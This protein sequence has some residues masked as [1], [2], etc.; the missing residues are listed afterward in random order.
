MGTLS[1][2][3]PHYVRCIKPNDTKEAFQFHPA[4]AVN[5]LRA[6]GVL[7][8]IRISAAGFPSRWL[9]QDF[10]HRYRL[11]CLHKEID[12]GDI[13]GTCGR[14]LAKHLKDPD[15]YQ[16]G[17]TKIFFRAGQV[18]YLEKIRA[19]IQRLYCVR[20]QSC[21]RRFVARQ[22]YLRLTR[23]LRGLQARARGFLARRFVVRQKYLRLTRALRGLQARARGFLARRAKLELLKLVE[24][25][26]K[27]L[28]AGNNDKDSLIAALQAELTSERD[29][30]K[31]LI[32]E[33]KE[34]EQAYKKEREEWQA[35]S[36]KLEDELRSNKEHY[37]MAIEGL[38]YTQTF[39]YDSSYTC[40][41]S[42]SPIG[43]KLTKFHTNFQSLFYP[44][45]GRIDQNTFLA[46]AYV[47][48]S[49]CMPNFSPIRPVFEIVTQTL[50]LGRTIRKWNA[51]PA[52]V[53][54]PSYKLGSF[55]RG[56]KKQHAGRQ[57]E[58][59]GVAGRPAVAHL[60][61]WTLPSLNISNFALSP[62]Y[63]VFNNLTG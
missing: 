50:F 48:T 59:A 34:I 61:V 25:E 28:R 19:D 56:V 2:T 27:S 39:I 53:F 11:L 63:F 18:A 3:T 36:K 16:F 1:A 30:N 52:H 8:T 51:M 35:E 6:C 26:A 55:Q 62:Y 33:K 58:D 41:Q 32:E 4:R 38:Y 29:S 44:I 17:K 10:F 31:R 7:E 37:E 22:K 45:G 14:I 42:L 40:M 57:G 9:Y 12:R 47:I 23:A 20:V 49:T 24:I 15:K 46:D 60:H 43:L 5:Q 13:K 54:S 21:V